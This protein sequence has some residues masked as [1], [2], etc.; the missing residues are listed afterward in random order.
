MAE[1]IKLTTKENT[2]YS[3]R[4][5]TKLANQRPAVVKQNTMIEANTVEGSNSA[6]AAAI[7]RL[8][9]KVKKKRRIKLIGT[10]R[11]TDLNIRGIKV[12][13]TTMIATIKVAVCLHKLPKPS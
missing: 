9:P 10:L 8:S 4:G 12:A 1:I 5:I 7:K 2:R 3:K 6:V 11:D 13:R